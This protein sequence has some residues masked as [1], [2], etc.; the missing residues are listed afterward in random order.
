MTKTNKLFALLIVSFMVLGS[1]Q[2][3]VCAPQESFDQAFVPLA[4]TMATA[5]YDSPNITVILISPNNGSA[6]SGTFDIIVNIT[7]DFGPLNL[8]LFVEDLI[9]SAYNRTAVGAGNEWQQTLNVDSSTL[10]EGM[11]NFTIL[12]EYLAEKESMYLLYFVDNVSPNF[13]ISLENPANE[14]TV[15]GVFSIDL[16]ITSDYDQFDITVFVDGE[17]HAPYDPGV[18]GTGD[19]S[20]IIDTAG[21]W[22]GWNNI[23]LFF[24]YHV[25]EVNFEYSMYLTFL[26]DNDG[27][28]I[29]VEHQAPA[30]GT[31]VAGEFNV[32]LLIGSE[33]EPLEFTLFIEGNIDPAYNMTPIGIREQ[34]VTIDTNGLPEGALNFT[35]FFWYN[36]TGE[37]AS[38]IY[39]LVFNVNNHGA[40]TVVILAPTTGET[41]T[42][43]FDLYLNITS[44]F[45][46]LYLNITVD[47]VI[48][49]EFN[50][51]SIT[52][53]AFN[54]AINSSRYDNGEFTI[55]IV[56]YT[57]EGE[58]FSTSIDVVFL[59]HVR[60]FFSGMTSYDVIAGLAQIN[61]LVQTPYDNVTA[62]LYV[63]DVLAN[64][65]VN[66]TL[67]P[68]VNSII[69]NT[70]VFPDGES[71][72]SIRVY[73]IYGHKYIRTIILI[74]DNFGPPT[75]RFATTDDVV[76]GL[77][78]FTVNVETTWTSLL[79]I[80]Y[81]DNVIV[82]AYNN[83]ST[84]VSGGTF[85]FYIDVG[86]YSKTEHTVKVLMT[87]PEGD[88]SD[89]SRVF[90][91]ATFRIEEIISII[92]ILFVAFIL[93]ISR[94]R[95]GHS[96]KP[97]LI[98]DALFI[99]VIVGL[100]LVLG[101]NTLAFI[102][103]HVNLAS[104]WTIGV[105]LV[106]TNWLVPLM[107]EESE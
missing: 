1:F 56:A 90:G 96:I 67:N 92:A 23:T 60:A 2:S 5:G 24:E 89:V 93:P 42:G 59:D 76:I 61:I 65:I 79:V 16:N 39:H 104:I 95:K 37:E 85:T 14:T 88:T 43:V 11:L 51:T 18:I 12:L 84:D 3:Q 22:E 102:T 64:D 32:T 26:V 21:F 69:F 19:V 28:P 82:P 7:S 10:S 48:T 77:A 98:A 71:Q 70:T 15:S 41:V 30:N 63:D 4:E 36:A 91:F 29:S 103:W 62:S 34:I 45:P 99:M 9:Y 75:L 55:G 33:Y 13:Q 87:T 35:F 100:F 6:V 73:D 49:P 46:E 57:G 105:A 107:T 53:G 86:N 66:V 20:L 17:A 74:V 44:T 83:I 81:V 40:P 97:V 54:Y 38:G 101:I 58:S 47:G 50:A 94:W 68:G 78:R 52:S 31:D 27:V 72:V 106:F 25:L 8:T 80:V